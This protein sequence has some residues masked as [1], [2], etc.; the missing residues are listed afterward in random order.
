M[1]ISL[2]R[3]YFHCEVLRCKTGKCFTGFYL[4]LSRGCVVN[5]EAGNNIFYVHV[6]KTVCYSSDIGKSLTMVPDWIHN[7]HYRIC[8]HQVSLY[9]LK[10]FSLIISEEVSKCGT[11]LQSG[12][13]I[14]IYQM[15][16]LL[17]GK[18]GRTYC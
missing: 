18:P 15:K 8:T 14:S 6:G 13:V 3:P 10:L 11:L 16:N 4:P 9:M 2:P 7:A 17:F 5:S 1:L 12:S